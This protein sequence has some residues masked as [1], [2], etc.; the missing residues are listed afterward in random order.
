VKQGDEGVRADLET[1]EL[2]PDA[3]LREI[4]ASYRRLRELYSKGSIAT[5]PLEDDL[6][7]GE[8]EALLRR[9]DEAYGR[10]TSRA[11]EGGA[12]GGEELKDTPV[13]EEGLKALGIE[14]L[15]GLGLRAL[16]EKLGVEIGEIELKSRVSAKHL[17]NIEN[18]DFQSLPEDVY[19]QGYVSIYAR[20]LGV[21]RTRAVRDFMEAL[22]EWRS[23]GGEGE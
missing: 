20:Y 15:D 16:R 23:G 8:R 12:A 4:R 21:D 14:R 10:L 11:Q 19:V 17:E 5:S 9:L 3:S 13:D 7:E 22:N 6:T 18:H 2:P 1:L